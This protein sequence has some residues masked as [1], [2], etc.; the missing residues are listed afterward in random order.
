MLIHVNGHSSLRHI[1]FDGRNGIF[2]VS[3]LIYL[4]TFFADFT[5]ARALFVHITGD[6]EVTVM[7]DELRREVKLKKHPSDVHN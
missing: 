6:N 2:K 3:L 5:L 4:F 1:A 7:M